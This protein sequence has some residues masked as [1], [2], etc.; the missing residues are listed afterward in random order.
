MSFH[1]LNSDELEFRAEVREF[2][3]RELTPAMIQATDTHRSLFPPPSVTLP[4]QRK[5]LER[6]WLAPHWPAE[7]GGSGWTAMQHF[8]FDTEAGRAGAPI[9]APFGLKYL[10]PVLIKF[11]TDTQRQ[12]YLPRILSGDD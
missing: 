4:W 1:G 5:L 9:L 2:L 7:Y 11:G 10:G 12:R 8:I 3:G 6:R